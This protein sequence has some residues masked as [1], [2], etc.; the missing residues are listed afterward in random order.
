M[1]CVKHVKIILV[2]NI[3]H[4]GLY[5]TGFVQNLTICSI[6]T[7]IFCLVWYNIS[8]SSTASQRDKFPDI[9]IMCPWNVYSGIDIKLSWICSS[10][11]C[12]AVAKSQNSIT[13]THKPFHVHD[14]T[15]FSEFKLEMES[16]KLNICSYKNHK[17]IM[18][19]SFFSLPSHFM[20]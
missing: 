20:A 6:V 1:T 18:S 5:Y 16:H 17:L 8:H 13:C 12:H 10:H 7:H 9:W 11:S 4:T 15:C 14:F 2:L 19:Q 3:L